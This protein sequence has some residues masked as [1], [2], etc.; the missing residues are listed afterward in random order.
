[1]KEYFF[2]TFK[3]LSVA[4]NYLRPGNEPFDIETEKLSNRPNGEIPVQNLK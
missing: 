2:V 1:M 3:G 4:R